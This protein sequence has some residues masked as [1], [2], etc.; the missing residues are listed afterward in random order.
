M[1]SFSKF[2]WNRHCKDPAAKRSPEGWGVCVLLYGVGCL[3]LCAHGFCIWQ[4]LAKDTS[5]GALQQEICHLG[6]WQASPVLINW[7][8]SYTGTG[9]QRPVA[10]PSRKSKQ[11]K[12]DITW[13]FHLNIWSKDIGSIL[14]H[15]IFAKFGQL[16]QERLLVLLRACPVEAWVLQEG[17]VTISNRNVLWVL[18]LSHTWN[19]GDKINLPT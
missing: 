5:L 7:S 14:L 2:G 19:G 11:E 1:T 9:C 10:A 18:L 16:F 4:K 8:L 17:N 13:S 12:L 15:F 3:F 6:Q